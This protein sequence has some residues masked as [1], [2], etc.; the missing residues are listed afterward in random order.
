MYTC[1]EEKMINKLVSM[2]LKGKDF[3]IIAKN[4]LALPLIKQ[5][6]LVLISK[7]YEKIATLM[8]YEDL[9]L[10]FIKNF[11]LQPNKTDIEALVRINVPDTLSMIVEMIERKDENS[12][13]VLEIAEK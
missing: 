8:D 12:E 2:N 3:N 10:I 13:L 9:Y 11:P 7:L 1:I 4:I 6:I 5:P